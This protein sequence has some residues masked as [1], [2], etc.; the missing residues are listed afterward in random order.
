LDN[1]P[2]GFRTHFISGRERRRSL[3]TVGD[4]IQA[5]QASPGSPLPNTD[6]G[7]ITLHPPE[8]VPRS[9]LAEDCLARKDD[10]KTIFRPDCE[11]N[12]LGTIGS[13][14]M[15]PLIIK[16]QMPPS[17]SFS[18]LHQTFIDDAAL[19]RQKFA[20]VKDVNYIAFPLNGKN[21]LFIGDQLF[22]QLW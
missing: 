19:S 18:Q 9:E 3:K 15:Q 20:K 7:L 1:Q 4:L 21:N 6:S 12:K 16:S 2:V 22:R 13:N 8:G 17:M 11:L 14:Y 10:G 5:Y